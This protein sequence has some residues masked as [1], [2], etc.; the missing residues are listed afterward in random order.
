VVKST[1]FDAAVPKT[2]AWEKLRVEV[3]NIA[4]AMSKNLIFIGFVFRG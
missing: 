2:G 4:V 1:N 3:N